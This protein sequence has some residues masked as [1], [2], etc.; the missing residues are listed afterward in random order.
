MIEKLRER[1]RRAGLRLARTTLRAFDKWL[2]E[3]GRLNA[4]P[5]IRNYIRGRHM[6]QLGA[7]IRRGYRGDW[8]GMCDACGT[9][10]ELHVLTSEALGTFGICS[11]P[12]NCAGC[13]RELLL[14]LNITKTA[15]RPDQAAVYATGAWSQAL[16]A[17]TGITFDGGF[18]ERCMDRLGQEMVAALR[19]HGVTCDL[20]LD[21]DLVYLH[22]ALHPHAIDWNLPPPG[23]A[24]TK[25]SPF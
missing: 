24:W 9:L 19:C 2:R 25:V 1:I 11:H 12:D 7:A 15:D 18:N 5:H 14:E 8:V 10:C 4:S 23:F 20:E 22:G 16:V 21:P 6:A 17:A 13:G 3:R